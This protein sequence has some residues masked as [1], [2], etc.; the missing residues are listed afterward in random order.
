MQVGEQH[1]LSNILILQP[2][3]PYAT[4][5]YDS[6]FPP[7]EKLGMEPK[8]KAALKR[9]GNLDGMTDVDVHH[10]ALV[11]M[12]N[13]CGTNLTAHPGLEDTVRF[14]DLIILVGEVLHDIRK[15]PAKPAA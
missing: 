11:Q 9:L 14:K 7:A 6:S 12:H 10:V 15:V 2:D 8:I 4:E 13:L 1:S 5:W 3:D